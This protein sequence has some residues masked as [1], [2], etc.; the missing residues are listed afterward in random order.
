MM[1]HCFISDCTN[2]QA[3][4][5]AFCDYHHELICQSS[6]LTCMALGCSNMRKDNS[7]W[8]KFH[9]KKPKWTWQCLAYP[10]KTCFMADCFNEANT[11]SLLCRKCLDIVSEF[12]GRY[13]QDDYPTIRDIWRSNNIM[14]KK[15]DL[16][17]EF[18]IRCKCGLQAS[19]ARLWVYSVKTWILITYY[20][21]CIDEDF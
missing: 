3:K 21:K 17:F 9:Y 12:C 10:R 8:C 19:H 5:S 15:N 11:S 13:G 16:Y 18:R 7:A 4:F 1:A 20:H 2:N 6:Q 14:F